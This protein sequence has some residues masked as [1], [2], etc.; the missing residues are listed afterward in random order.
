MK[1]RFVFVAILLSLA[2]SALVLAQEQSGSSAS[3]P[4]F[5]QSPGVDG[6]GIRNYLLGPGD[7]IDVRVFGQPDLSATVEIDSDGN[8]SSLPFLE[9]PIVA[10]CRTEKALQKDIA[11]AYGKYVKNPQVSVR[12]S[13]R[14]SR[15]PATVFGAVRQPAR[16]TMQRK[17]RLNELIA[18]SGGFTERASGTIQIL[19][20]EPLMCPQPG[21]EADAAPIDGTRLPLQIV[22]ISDL[23]AGLP[24]ANP[25][26]RP[27]DI[28]QVT[29]AE[30]IYVTGSVFSPQGIY[31]RDQL[32]LS[33]AL[34]MVGGV[35]SEAKTSEVKIYR[36]KP[37]STE[38]ETILVD[39]GA[40][41]KNKIPDVFL[42]AF[43]VIE[44][45]EAGMF[46][47]SRIGKTLVGAASGG[48]G[49]MFSSGGMSLANK[50]IY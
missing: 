25:V 12:I 44:V 31:L 36:Q 1:R 21:E 22:K 26:I 37:G 33:R 30:P 47:A 16:V 46:S 10:R 7:V 43:D 11:E 4:A 2:L 38:Q 27:G 35:K 48:L 8:V 49:N 40:I 28:L 20:T 41:K 15:Q 6:Q 42:Q 24:Q 18:S 13:E 34:A 45:P 5:S 19:H 9:T 14:K 29:E 39:Y 50:V 3:G 23:R 17:V 32:T